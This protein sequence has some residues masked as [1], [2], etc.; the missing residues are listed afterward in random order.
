[1]QWDSRKVT[2]LL[3]KLLQPI[4]FKIPAHFGHCFMY[5]KFR[6]KACMALVAA[7][8]SSSF[9]CTQRT[10]SLP[11]LWVYPQINKPLLHSIMGYYG[12][13][14]CNNKLVPESVPLPGPGQIPACGG[15][16]Y[17]MQLNYHSEAGLPLFA[18]A[19][20]LAWLV[21]CSNM[22][23]SCQPAPMWFGF[24]YAVEL[25]LPRFPAITP[26]WFLWPVCL[27]SASEVQLLPCLLWAG[28]PLTLGALT[29]HLEYR[30]TFPVQILV[31]A[32]AS[33]LTVHDCLQD[34]GSF[35]CW[36]THFGCAVLS[37]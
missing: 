1:M 17:L 23:I 16:S 20:G 22:A 10:V 21:Y 19:Q 37:N 24:A 27:G 29:L 9:Q 12:T 18:A 35:T 14:W 3:W 8:F 7:G 15:F 2:E 11:L 5:Y 13:L 31:R 28:Q 36:P 25:P 4:A 26:P 6:W 34:V 32:L 30:F 33:S